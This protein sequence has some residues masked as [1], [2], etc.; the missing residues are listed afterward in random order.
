M[1]TIK[2]EAK[3]LLPVVYRACIEEKSTGNKI[4]VFSKINTEPNRVKLIPV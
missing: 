1:N 2:E 3:H 4:P